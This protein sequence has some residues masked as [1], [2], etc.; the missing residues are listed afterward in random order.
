MHKELREEYLERLPLLEALRESLERETKD[1]LSGYPHVDR[2]GFRVKGV[3]SFVLK[4]ED[5]KNAPTYSEP[6]VEIEDQVAG[7]VIVFFSSDLSDVRGR[8]EATFTT[9]ERAERHPPRDAE[10]G[11]ESDHLICVIPPHLKPDGWTDREDVPSTFEIQIRTLFMHAYA[12]PQHDLAYKAADDLPREVRRELAWIAASAWGADRAYERV[13]AW[14]KKR[15]PG[16]DA[17]EGATRRR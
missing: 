7:R 5:P 4:A 17:A 12:E 9:V 10:F 16:G 2:I 14:S 15:A 1:A 11:Y 8:L 6:L 13:R 3:G